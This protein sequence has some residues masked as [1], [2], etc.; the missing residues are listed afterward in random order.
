MRLYYV[1]VNIYIGVFVSGNVC[2]LVHDYPTTIP[3]SAPKHQFFA[4][5]KWNCNTGTRQPKQIYVKMDDTVNISLTWLIKQTD[6]FFVKVV[7]R[8]Q[9]DLY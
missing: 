9:A 3:I 5:R 4:A 8:V 1:S 6:V 2:P 7:A